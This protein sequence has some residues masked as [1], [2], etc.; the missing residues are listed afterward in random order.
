MNRLHDKII[1]MEFLMWVISIRNNFDNL[2]QSLY[3]EYD[4]CDILE[5]FLGQ[6]FY[7]IL[8]L[9]VNLYSKYMLQQNLEKHHSC[10]LHVLNLFGYYLKVIK[11]DLPTHALVGVK[12]L[13][14]ALI[15]TFMCCTLGK[16]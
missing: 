9:R 3:M 10:K 8:H 7:P 5:I 11:K 16:Q 1:K 12:D 15:K 14:Y 13:I 2:V 6:L 4:I